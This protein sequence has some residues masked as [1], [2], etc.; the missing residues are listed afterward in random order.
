MKTKTIWA[1]VGVCEELETSLWGGSIEHLWL[2][3]R[4]A[5][6][7][8]ENQKGNLYKIIKLSVKVIK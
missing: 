8:L 6:L 3:K 2:K 4:D 5:K 7:D 1:V